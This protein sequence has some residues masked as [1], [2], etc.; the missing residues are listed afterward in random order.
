MSLVWAHDVCVLWLPG[1][2]T[3]EVWF[4]LLKEA[5]YKALNEEEDIKKKAK[6]TKGSKYQKILY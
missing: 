3:L 1:L 2:V 5:R 6:M 4:Q